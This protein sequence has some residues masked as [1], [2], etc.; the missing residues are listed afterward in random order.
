MAKKLL[1]SAEG[2]RS[3]GAALILNDQATG[4]RIAAEVINSL[5]KLRS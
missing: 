4:Q 5:Q 2:L 3:F 1:Q